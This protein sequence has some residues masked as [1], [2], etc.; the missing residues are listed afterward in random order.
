MTRRDPVTGLTD[1]EL[2]ELAEAAYEQRDNPDAW[3]DEERPEISPDVRSV[4][5]VRFSKGELGPIERAAAASGVP[6]STYIRNAAVN[7]VSAV[8]LDEARRSLQAL[9]EDLASLV[10]ALGAETA[11][12][13][14]RRRRTSRPAV[15]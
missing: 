10:T 12:R 7:A 5:S 2:A 14:R 13:E 15:A 6:V 3:V 1:A 11:K 8:D 9:Q 4:V